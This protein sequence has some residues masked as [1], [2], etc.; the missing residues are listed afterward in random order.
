MIQRITYRASN[1]QIEHTS[2]GYVIAIM[3]PDGVTWQALN[4]DL[5]SMQ[6]AATRAKNIVDGY[7]DIQTK[8]PREMAK[9]VYPPGWQAR[10]YGNLCGCTHAKEKRFGSMNQEKQ[11]FWIGKCRACKT[12]TRGTSYGYSFHYAKDD[13]KR[14]GDVYTGPTS[15]VLNDFALDCRKCGRAIH[16]NEIRGRYNPNKKCTARCLA[17]TGHDCECSCAGKNHGA[18]FSVG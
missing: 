7:L 15:Y 3:Y 4:S 10:R 18:S 1:I 6:Q 14:R 17:A 5:R 2:R 12:A 11:R 8:L 13:P 16:A 9:H